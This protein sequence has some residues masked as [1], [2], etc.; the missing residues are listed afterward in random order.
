MNVVENNLLI[1]QFMGAVI[2]DK[3]IGHGKRDIDFDK[4]VS[5]LRVHKREELGY[6]LSWD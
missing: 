5:G 2:L 3:P 4:I 1:A 6:H